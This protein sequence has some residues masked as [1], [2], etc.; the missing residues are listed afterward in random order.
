LNTV[1]KKAQIGDN[2]KIGDYTVIK[3]DVQIGNNVDIGSNVLI[4]DGARISDDV[5]I[6]HGAVVSSIPQDLKFKGE[7]SILQIGK[8]SIIREYATLNRGTAFSGKTSI[9]KNCLIMAY[10]HVAHDCTLG[11]NVILANCVNL[12]GHVFIDEWAIIGGIIGI[13]QFCK[14]GKHVIIASHSRIVKDVPPYITAGN[15]PLKFEGLN[16]VGLKRRNFTEKQIKNITDVYDILYKSGL[17]F[18]D[19]VKKIEIEFKPTAEVKEI[20]N[21]VKSSE[22]GIIR[23]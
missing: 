12:G 3:D 7:D 5:K 15:F 16:L 21:F 17:N 9:G 18:G 1:S 11:D 13:H 10:G 4:C 6:H 20:L 8:G 19:A 14:I 2:V 23:I 22:R